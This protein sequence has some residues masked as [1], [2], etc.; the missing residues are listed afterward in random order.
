[1]NH[2]LPTIDTLDE[3]AGVRSAATR[4]RRAPNITR[5]SVSEHAVGKVTAVGDA[6][7]YYIE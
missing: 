4:I 5:G 6:V 1:M 7:G 3:N 2:G